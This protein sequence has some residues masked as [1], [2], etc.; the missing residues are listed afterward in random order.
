MAKAYTPNR[1]YTS[2]EVAMLLLLRSQGLS[3]KEI[4]AKLNRTVLGIM[5]KYE[6]V[7]RN[8]IIPVYATDKTVTFKSK[9]VAK[10]LSD[11]TIEEIIEYLWNVGV[12][13]IDNKPVIYKPIE[14]NFK[15]NASQYA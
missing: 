5:M 6:K 7:S 15:R 13:I 4:A 1:R 12:R 2:E 9:D 14:I 10:S 3:Y 8:G 11:Y